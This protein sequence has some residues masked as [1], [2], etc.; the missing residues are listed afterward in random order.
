[1]SG[2]LQWGCKQHSWALQIQV[3]DFISWITE[4]ETEIN[5][6]SHAFTLCTMM[7]SL[8][9]SENMAAISS[10]AVMDICV[11]YNNIK[12]KKWSP[13]FIVSLIV[14]LLNLLADV[15][16]TKA[17]TQNPFFVVVLSTWQMKLLSPKTK[18]RFQTAE[19]G[20]QLFQSPFLLQ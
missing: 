13:V 1:M 17:P 11:Y 16:D 3:H 10:S 7:N 15:P 8:W 19:M 5:S 14:S 2:R 12:G 4:M 18:N 20:R 6:C 9:Q